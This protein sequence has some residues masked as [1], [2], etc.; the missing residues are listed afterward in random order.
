MPEPPAPDRVSL[1]DALLARRSRRFARGMRLDAGPLAFASAQPPAPLSL[2]DEA[3]LAF[4][5]C[6]VTGYALGELP[7]QGTPDGPGG[8]NIMAQ[9]VGRTAA[10]GDALHVCTVFVLNDQGAWM[11][12]RPPDFPRSELPALV[13]LARQRK[14]VELYER[15]RVR[16]ADR[17]PD[18]PRAWPFV[19]PFNLPSANVPGSTY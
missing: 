13:E 14:F 4:A 8:G 9:F 5:A 16:V 7:Y 15:S 3:L 11:L 18:P 2:E 1:I 10:S 19:P 6:G 17:R 12:R